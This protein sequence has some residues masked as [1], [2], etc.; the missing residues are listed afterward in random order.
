MRRG[1][2][3]LHALWSRLE[4]NR[5]NTRF[6]LELEAGRR[7]WPRSTPPSPAG[8]L[9]AGLADRPNPLSTH[10]RS[11]TL[12]KAIV[13]ELPPIEAA[14][15]TLQVADAAVERWVELRVRVMMRLAMLAAGEGGVERAEGAEPPLA[16]L[17]SV[18]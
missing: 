1:A 6:G 13:P 3:A 7:R 12:Q 5:K 14:W 18:T 16:P 9:F 17:R 10:E 4:A 11:A 8:R 2:L 15:P